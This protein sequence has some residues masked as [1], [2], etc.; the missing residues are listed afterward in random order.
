MRKIRIS[1][2]EL[3]R[4]VLNLGYVGENEHSQILI[5]C[6]SIFED[7][8]D[9][10]ATMMVQL[11]NGDTYPKTITR[12]GVWLEWTVADSDLGLAGNGKYQLTFTDSGEVIKSIIGATTISASLD[13][14][15]TPTPV[16]TWLETA[17]EM[18]AEMEA[19][20]D[21]IEDMTVEAS[22]LAAGEDATVT[23]SDVSGHKHLA[24]GLPKGDKGDTGDVEVVLV[25]GSDYRILL[26]G[27]NDD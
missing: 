8:P 23:V 7:Y 1:V 27:A 2:W 11:P 22:T 6:N 10:V 4:R 26:G 16:E 3:D 15:A 18:L 5:N 24:F 21:A 20:T 12:D 17:N 19:A 13:G 14:S 25:S 9:A